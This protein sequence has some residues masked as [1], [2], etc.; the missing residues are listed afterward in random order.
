MRAGPARVEVAVAEEV[1]VPVLLFP[2]QVL[3]EVYGRKATAGE[4][5]EECVLL[6]GRLTGALVCDNG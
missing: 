5:E 4:E 3:L 2:V 1:W 6:G